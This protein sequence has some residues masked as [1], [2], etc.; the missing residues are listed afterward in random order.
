MRR[1]KLRVSA[2]TQ[3][4]T[5]AQDNKKVIMYYFRKKQVGD[6]NEYQLFEYDGSF[7]YLY[8][9]TYYDYVSCKR[10]KSGKQFLYAI[11]ELPVELQFVYMKSYLKDYKAISRYYQDIA[12]YALKADSGAGRDHDYFKTDDGHQ[13]IHLIK[14]DPSQYVVILNDDNAYE[15]ELKVETKCEC[16]LHD[17]NLKRRTAK[18]QEELDRKD[19]EQRVLDLMEKERDRL[20]ELKKKN[21]HYKLMSDSE[22]FWEHFRA[23]QERISS[24][25]INLDAI[26]GHEYLEEVTPMGVYPI[27]QYWY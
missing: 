7:Y 12:Y 6:K 15:S 16:K 8:I 11:D 24:Q 22:K 19:E 2:D 18:R 23:N 14:Y 13:Y 1:K 21:E 4:Q 25:G 17:I 10:H 20:Y 26:D 5:S 3:Q 9:N 27:P